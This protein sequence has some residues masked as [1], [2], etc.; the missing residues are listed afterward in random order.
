MHPGFYIVS[1]KNEYLVVTFFK[2]FHVKIIN[3]L[4]DITNYGYLEP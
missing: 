3:K 2:T 4:T 1:H